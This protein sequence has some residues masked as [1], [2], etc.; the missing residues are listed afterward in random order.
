M[1]NID[2][3]EMMRAWALS[4]GIYDYTQYLNDVIDRIIELE[5]ELQQTKEEL[6]KVKIMNKK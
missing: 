2:K 3:L 1:K 5:R 4:N 6:E